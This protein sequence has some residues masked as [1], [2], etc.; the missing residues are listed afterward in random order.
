[1]MLFQ[2][3]NKKEKMLR[4]DH[5]RTPA[6]YISGPENKSDDK[7]LKLFICLCIFE[8]KY[9][10]LLKLSWNFANQS[11]FVYEIFNNAEIFW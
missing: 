11:D 6:S 10:Y 3:M 4:Y 9:I 5:W 1:M 8:S 7:F 2:K